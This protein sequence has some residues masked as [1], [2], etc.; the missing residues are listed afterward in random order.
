MLEIGVCADR[1]RWKS[2]LLLPEHPS[3]SEPEEPSLSHNMEVVF[4]MAREVL[5]YILLLEDTIC[6]V[7][8][9]CLDHCMNHV[10]IFRWG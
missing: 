1:C 7:I 3:L 4:S 5:R 9:C 10:C 6:Y 8:S 2:K